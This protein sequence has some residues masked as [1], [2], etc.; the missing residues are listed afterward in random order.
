MSKNKKFRDWYEEE[1]SAEND[2]KFSKT[3]SKRYDKKK[4]KIQDA[5]KVKAREKDSYFT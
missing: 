1:E 4:A 2:P 5:R 3:D